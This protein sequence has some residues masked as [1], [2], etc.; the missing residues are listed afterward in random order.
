MEENNCENTVI[1][2][3]LIK[4]FLA[5]LVGSINCILA[6]FACYT[7]YIQESTSH[8]NNNKLRSFLYDKVRL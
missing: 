3:D 7:K 6:M 8:M 4:Y 5:G 1:S 2:H